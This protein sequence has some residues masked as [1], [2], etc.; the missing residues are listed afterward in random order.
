MSTSD[1]SDL[2]RLFENSEIRYLI[3]GGHA[4]MSYTEPRFTK[5][6]DIWVDQ[7]LENAERVYVALARFGAPLGG[8]S[9]ANFSVPDMIFQIGLPPVR[10][11]ILTSIA[12]L[13]FAAAWER[14][15]RRPFLGASAWFISREDLLRNKEAVGRPRDL[16]DAE[17][18]RLAARLRK[19]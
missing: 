7:A 4:V 12:G 14:R 6:L 3:V 2:L 15:Q 8:S 19:E 10:I 1:F 9:P 11:D 17:E 18:L 5:D 16:I 13:E